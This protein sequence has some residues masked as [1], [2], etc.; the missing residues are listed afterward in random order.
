VKPFACRIILELFE[1]FASLL[2]DEHERNVLPH[3]HRQVI[4]DH[5][6]EGRTLEL[7]QPSTHV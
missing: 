1:R 3:R 7:K 4:D 5:G 2:S 6:S